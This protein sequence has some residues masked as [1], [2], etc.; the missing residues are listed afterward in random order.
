MITIV[1]STHKDKEYNN[2]FKTHLSN[3]VGLND[4]QI[5]EY[6][7]NNQYS[8]AQVYNSGITEA[9]YNI[10]VCCH[11]DIK[12]E[13]NWGKKL[14]DDF[15]NNPE[16]GII[17]KAGSCYFPET[18]VYWERMQQTM[19]GQVWHHPDGHKKWINNYSPKLPFIV[20]VVTIDGLFI[21]FDKTK[22]KH[23]FDET[24]GKF[25]FYDH[26]FTIPNY[27]DGV[28]LGVTSSFEITHESIGQPNQ[29]FWESKDIFIKK[30]KSN[31]PL[32]LKPI[33]LFNNSKNVTK[34]KIK[35]KVAIIIENS[36]LGNTQ[37]TINSFLQNCDV[38]LFDIFIFNQN[39]FQSNQVNNVHFINEKFES[40]TEG[41][42]YIVKNYLK[43]IHKYLLFSSGN[44]HFNFDVINEFLNV[45]RLKTKIGTI[46]CRI[47]NG[48][49][50]INQN[51]S[52]IVISKEN[53]NIG[54]SKL[55]EKN[56]YNFRLGVNEI[57][58]NTSE[59]F[60]INKNTFLQV[61][62]FDERYKSTFEDVYLN[63]VL[64]TKGF[65]NYIN[66]DIFVVKDV[67][68]SKNVNEEIK[69]FNDYY[70]PFFKENYQK[71]KHKIITI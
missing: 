28:K 6:Q 42:N 68:K 61:G 35:E 21:S 13:K 36:D 65:I 45:F 47:H 71:L 63:S 11:N 43:E 34:F 39:D 2:K 59:F 58:I 38:N 3:S 70:L 7:N 46:G 55:D 20:P 69:N 49:N 29:E 26:G 10:V 67:E 30:Y 8:L 44:I 1:Y 56:Y 16:F 57:P 54:I 62:M 48:D 15:E 4:V 22:I 31:L 18:G 24:I 37:K 53:N 41:K 12:L 25:H 17:G 52:A 19:V 50:T 9:I 5:L 14:I 64:I 32:D 66:S 51:G 40:S 27:L 33:Q 23:K 60:I